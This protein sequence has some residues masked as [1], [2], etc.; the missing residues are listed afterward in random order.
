MRVLN[1][2]SINIDHVYE[3]DHFVR[4][5]ETLGSLSYRS[6]A[7]GKGFNQSLALARA[8]VATAHA[9]RVGRDAAWLLKRLEAEGID[10]RNV[11]VDEAATGHAVIQVAPNGEN[12]IFLF[13]GSNKRITDADVVNAVSYCQ[14]DDILL[15]Q[16]ETSSV[17]RAIQAA[18]QRGLRI[19]FNPAPMSLDVHQY[20]LELVDIFILNESEAE[21]LTGSREIMAVR[22]NMLERFPG[23]AVVL[24]QGAQ[25]ATY[26]DTEMI[27]HEAALPV[28]PVD[29]TGAGDTFI[30]FF[31]AE[32][33]TT[34]KPTE[35]MAKACRAA[36]I[37]V[38]KA[39]ASDS[40]PSR[41]ELE[42]FRP[43]DI[44]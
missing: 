42:A 44:G 24:T 38:T 5:G 22:K 12:A 2:G 26:F 16:N 7:G 25:G 1:I 23:A 17:A 33:I 4:P 27:H 10:T 34:G 20:P 13:P 11:F 40:I 19:V 15:L 32:L 14:P 41:Q 8:G 35:A 31:L 21:V 3:V 43:E 36:A 9:G 6:L 30:G 18:R 37:C 39:G 29:T 28:N